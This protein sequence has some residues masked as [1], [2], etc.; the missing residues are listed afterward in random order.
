MA[1]ASAE[2]D[3]AV[4]PGTRFLVR[5]DEEISTGTAK[6]EMPFKA[7]T[8]DPLTT[9]GGLVLRPGAEIRGHIDKVEQA[10]QVGRSTSKRQEEAEAAAA[11]ALVG[12]APGVVEHNGKGAALG[13]ATG[14]VTAFMVGSGL[15]HELTL[16]KD[17]KLELIL[18][19]P[20]YLVGY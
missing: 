10:H 12:A 18:E 8:L 7:H 3:G 5:L 16:E 17:T 19:H 4:T 11:G 9:P 15:G 14:A 6:A 1:Q 2:R 13:A 20:L